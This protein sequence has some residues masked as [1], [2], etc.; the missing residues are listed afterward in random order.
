[1][2]LIDKET[3]HNLGTYDL[4]DLKCDTCY[5]VYQKTKRAWYYTA[6]KRK[7]GLNFETKNYCSDECRIKSYEI[8]RKQYNCL[9]CNKVFKGNI[10]KNPKFCGH[11]CAAKF[12]NKKRNQNK[13]VNCHDC[14]T[15][16]L[17][18]KSINQKY[19]RCAD[20]IKNNNARIELNK[21]EN[22]SKKKK[23]LIKN[24]KHCSNEFEFKKN[25]RLY[26]SSKCQINNKKKYEHS[27]IG[28]GKSYTNT[29]KYSKYCSN[30]CKSINLKLHIYAHKRSGKSRSQIELFVETKLLEDFP[31]VKFIF[32]DKDII[33]SELDVYIPE[34]KLAI[35][36]NGIVHYEPIYGEE[37]LIKVQNKDKQKMINCYQQGIELIVIPLGVKGLSAS[38]T[39]EIYQGIYNIISNNKNRILN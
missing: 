30:S 33:G 27:C 26:C 21:I 39:Q 2:I 34:L 28:C 19:Y 20:C 1:M 9:E 14:S 25:K 7:I 31:E 17:I 12:N 22:L 4:V 32:N 10:K 18:W 15:E 23:L 36:L 37:R 11:S 8:N 24:C 35:E 3:Y 16:F 13:L 6:Y 5:N 38:K 29:E